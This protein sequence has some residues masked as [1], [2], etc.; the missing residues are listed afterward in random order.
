MPHTR[1]RLIRIPYKAIPAHTR[2]HAHIQPHTTTTTIAYHTTR[3]H[4]YIGGV[5]VSG[6]YL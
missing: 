5:G 3:H 4:I 6:A 1:V 2:P